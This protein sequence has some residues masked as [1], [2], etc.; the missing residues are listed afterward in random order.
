[1][2]F[3][4]ILIASLILAIITLSAVSAS[5]DF[6][7]D[8]NLTDS[9][10]AQD[11][12][13]KS[14]AEGDEAL[15]VFTP[16]DFDANIENEDSV[17][18]K[19][20]KDKTIVSVYCPS[21]SEGSFVV[22]VDS[23][24]FDFL[25]SDSDWDNEVGWKLTGLNITKAGTYTISLK[26]VPTIGGEIP[27][28]TG[29]TLTVTGV[30]FNPSIENEVTLDYTDNV[31]TVYCPEDTTG[32]FIV[33][34]DGKV[35][36]YSISSSDFD[37]FIGWTLND[38]SITTTGEYEISL[39]YVSEDDDELE[40]V[41]ETLI[42]SDEEEKYSSD[43]FNFNVA[44]KV[45]INDYWRTVIWFYDGPCDGDLYAYVNS[46]QVRHKSVEET[47]FYG[48][49]FNLDD[50]EIDTAGIYNVTVKFEYSEKLITLTSF[51]LNVT[52]ELTMYS[53]NSTLRSNLA[54]HSKIPVIIVECPEKANGNISVFHD[55]DLLSTKVIDNHTMYFTLDE[56]GISETKNEYSLTVCYGEESLNE[57]ILMSHSINV[58]EKGNDY[59]YFLSLNIPELVQLGDWG[60]TG[61]SINIKEI[62]GGT[63]TLYV[64]GKYSDSH[65]FD[66]WDSI[67]RLAFPYDLT[68]GEHTYNIT[69]SGDGVHEAFNVSGEF[70][71]SY[72]LFIW[73]DVENPYYGQTTAIR[74]SS[75]DELEEDYVNLTVNEKTIRV[76]KGSFIDVY[77]NDLKYGENNLTLSYCGDSKYPARSVTRTINITSKIKINEVEVGYNSGFESISLLLPENA[78]GS[79]VVYVDDEFFTSKELSNGKASVSIS[80]L[81]LN[82]YDI[83]AVYNGSDYIINNE[84]GNIDVVPN[85]IVLSGM[86]SK[87][88]NTIS[89]EMPEEF[90]GTLEVTI[91]PY[92]VDEYE[93]D[94]EDDVF[95][96]ECDVV[97]GMGSLT[98]PA[99][100]ITSK[101]RIEVTYVDNETDY[102][103]TIYK[104]VVFNNNT[105]DL[106]LD[107]KADDLLLGQR[108]ASV[109]IMLPEMYD[110]VLSAIINAKT[111]NLTSA[112]DY[113][114][115][116]QYSYQND[117]WIFDVSDLQLGSYNITFTFTND[118]YYDDVNKTVQVNVTP[119]IYG[120]AD[121]FEIGG[122]EY[123]NVRL[124]E[125]ATGYLTI[126]IDNEVNFNHTID[127]DYL[128][129]EDD[130][131]E[132]LWDGSIK[133]NNLTLGNHTYELI[134]DYNSQQ[135]V[136]KG[137]FNVS[138]LFAVDVEE[139]ILVYGNNITLE[140]YLPDEAEGNVVVDV[141]GKTY[142]VNRTTNYRITL[143]DL[144]L[145]DNLI[146][147][148]YL[149][150]GYFPSKTINTTVEMS[151]KFNISTYIVW[152]DAEISIEMPD[153][154]TGKFV[155][156][157]GGD[158]YSNYVENG[159]ATITLSDL[160][161]SGYWISAYYEGDDYGVLYSDINRIYIVPEVNI[162]VLS[163]DGEF[164]ITLTAPDTYNSD[165]T[166]NFQGKTYNGDFIDGEAIITV[167]NLNAGR[168]TMEININNYMGDPEFNF[169]INNVAVRSSKDN[170]TFSIDMSK[171]YLYNSSEYFEY[172]LPAGADGN[173][174]VKIDDKAY[175]IFKV[176][177]DDYDG[178][179]VDFENLTVGEHKIEFIYAGDSYYESSKI[180]ELFNISYI[181]FPN[182]VEAGYF[183]EENQNHYSLNVYSNL[184][185][186]IILLIDGAE[187]T[188]GFAML[189][190]TLNNITSGVHFYEIKFLGD[191][192]YT[193]FTK[194]G[195]FNVTYNM[196]VG[197]DYAKYGFE[198]K[199]SVELPKDATGEV[200]LSIN[201]ENITAQLINGKAN[202]TLPDLDVG[203][204]NLTVSYEGDEKY[205]AQNITD[206]VTVS[207]AVS[208]TVGKNNVTISVDLPED[209]EG[210]LYIEIDD[211]DKDIDIV[212]GKASYTKSDL[213]GEYYI[214]ARASVDEYDVCSF[215]DDVYIG[216]KIDI[217]FE[218]PSR[219]TINNNDNLSVEI[220]SED[221][222][223]NLTVYL[224]EPITEKL[225]GV[226]A[227]YTN[228]TG[229]FTISLLNL[230]TLGRYLLDIEFKTDDYQSNKF[231]FIGVTPKLT[232]D[233]D[234][235]IGDDKSLSIELPNDATGSVEVTF[236]Q[237]Y[238]NYT[239]TVNQSFNQGKAEFSLSALPVGI[240]SVYINCSDAKYGA[241][242]GYFAHDYYTEVADLFVNKEVP[243]ITAYNSTDTLIIQFPTNASGNVIVDIDGEDYAG[244]IVDGKVQI[245]NVDLSGVEE[246]SVTYSGDNNYASFKYTEAEINASTEPIIPVDP[247]LSVSVSNITVGENAVINV[248]I[249]ENITS[250]VVVN[251]N[252]E[253]HTVTLTNGIG[254]VSV[255]NLSNGTYEVKAMFKG[256]T[257]FTSSEKT[258]TLKVSKCFN[259]ITIIV[260][261]E[262]M[263]GSNFNILVSNLTAAEVTINNNPYSIIDGKIDIN[264]T[265]LAKG[266]YTINVTAGETEMYLSNSTASVFSIVTNPVDPNLTVNVDDIYVGETAIVHITINNEIDSGVVLNVGGEN[267]TVTLTNGVGNVSLSDLENGTY[268]VKAMFN[269][270]DYFTPSEKSTTLKVSKRLNPISITV[271]TEYKIGD[272]FNILVL[273]VTS[274]NVTI[275]NNVYSVVDGKVVV[276]TT[277]LAE[278]TYTVKASVSESVQYLANLTTATF[279]ISKYDAGLEVHASNINLGEIENISISINENV[280]GMV[281][282]SFNG[283]NSTVEIIN[284][285]ANI[286]LEDLKSGS[287]QILVSFLGDDKYEATHKTVSFNVIAPAPTYNPKIIAGNL[288][289]AYTSG[290]AFKVQV[291]GSDGNVAVGT[292]VQFKVNGVAVG[293]ALTDSKGYA[294]FKTTQVPGTYTITATALGKSSS[295]KLTVSG[296]LSLKSVTVKKSAKKLVL[297]A[298]LKKVNGK[299]LKSKKITFKF[300]GKKYSAKTNSKGIAK[301]TVKKSVLKKL[302]VGKKINYQAT[303]LKETTLKVVKVKK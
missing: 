198:N 193:A 117:A 99:L 95:E 175:E 51:T 73:D 12:I 131:Y 118:T 21:E 67:P 159:K 170:Y 132:S 210:T 268:E 292:L 186:G 97:E 192:K 108:D 127:E 76:E 48:C 82:N 13:E 93:Y 288:N 221:I 297:Q 201:N 301:V 37:E 98:I 136:K 83:F 208:V 19:N 249:N 92:T 6:T 266:T 66:E 8:N 254:N 23:N 25:I 149:D 284:G 139:T 199:I 112:Y 235:V 57:I 237:I 104:Y 228:V 110:G 46:T 298:T 42:V 71:V 129:D 38:L 107:I 203:E 258:T 153:N 207:Y 140:I 182:D 62:I 171:E 122:Y 264:T 219:T 20:D 78:T 229:K 212:D 94:Y 177:D 56:L 125:N 156:E 283:A 133:L 24:E 272:N 247:D 270:S 218:N 89:V 303:Y 180:T 250:G 174:T 169:D 281:V 220:N 265:A 128:Y 75:Y 273:N 181:I 53:F 163:K 120:V 178:V 65:E 72:S 204:Y 80:N 214:Y 77:L 222:K 70:N 141:A 278:G 202:F 185:G 121:E 241:F 259:P 84:S 236:N 215:S 238:G 195:L 145:G 246:I 41:S 138:Y 274:A 205:Y 197:V 176:S 90:N 269:G 60:S 183:D 155:I 14:C 289:T 54:I 61:I 248:I 184:T 143:T 124:A 286:S 296:I 11:S 148:T 5:D 290:E 36:N 234:I 49:T 31:V 105:R 111:Y 295:S 22:D 50:L 1:M 64:D 162:P 244:E 172:S 43:D 200:T 191:E 255:S 160:T 253:N 113:Y 242:M 302:K 168:Y 262:Y 52:D 291:Y 239:K 280:T 130:D 4:Y 68:L 216:Q 44:S 146:L 251:I 27:L 45:S 32:L 87:E 29:E 81:T 26:F 152:N 102:T 213:N 109:I 10:V 142:T 167:S 161:I 227:N 39:K 47:E 103:K 69:Y 106:K 158:E 34:V 40:L 119:I 245:N 217:S 261:S 134:F 59:D 96:G 74:V 240:F 260:N 35:F 206:T 100:D 151:P 188:R 164:N 7:S 299:Y 147:L 282:Y 9:E 88:E 263:I 126:K 293:N 63:I 267:H 85:V 17:D 86:Y 135:Y 209:A 101:C 157:I 257:Y 294:S 275:N 33:S 166:I 190:F 226:F 276:N 300:N 116:S 252:G 223:G 187:I 233:N 243:K 256:N 189:D 2:K 271:D 3:K 58:V 154:A 91:T 287:Y 231:A 232:M 179:Y 18:L 15:S 194:S 150:D 55:G 165:F 114:Y 277:E 123:I 144:Q 173:I 115:Y 224:R 79:L 30:D 211:W 28:L 230:T 285:K 196:N 279:K 16:D 137:K 225:L